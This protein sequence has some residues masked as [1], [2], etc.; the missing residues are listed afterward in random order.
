MMAEPDDTTP[1]NALKRGRQGRRARLAGWPLA[2]VLV[3]IVLAALD[4]VVIAPF[5]AASAHR[6]G[7]ASGPGPGRGHTATG[8][9]QHHGKHK[10]HRTR[11]RRRDRP[12]S[13]LCWIRSARRRSGP[14]ASPQETTRA[15]RREAIDA[16]ATT[17]WQTQWYA[18]AEFGSLKTGTGLLVDMGRPVRITSV[19]DPAYRRNRCRRPGV[20]RRRASPGRRPGP[21]HR[22]GCGRRREAR[23]GQTSE[24][25]VPGDLVHAAAARIGGQV[26]GA[27]LQHPVMGTAGPAA[28]GL[29]ARLTRPSQGACRIRGAAASP[30]GLAHRPRR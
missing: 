26:P 1:L 5:G 21:G 17:A 16:S 8:A 9:R 28:A 25:E 3:W 14:T 30:C 7:N 13:P 29:T 6:V 27:R 12:S 15:A 18:T 19:T 24:S 2:L 4:I 20:Y 23:P 22:P 10:H 11:S